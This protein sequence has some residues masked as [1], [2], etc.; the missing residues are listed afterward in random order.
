MPL[1]SVTLPAAGDAKPGGFVV[2]P[3]RLVL[4]GKEPAAVLTLQ[5]DSSQPARFELKMFAW[6]EGPHGEQNLTRTE[7]VLFFPTIFPLAAGE[8]RIVRLAYR[9]SIGPVEKTYRLIMSQ[10]PSV[11]K[12]E[13][14]PPG[15]RTLIRKRTLRCRCAGECSLF[16]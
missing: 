16:K 2:T 4:S 13:T 14:P 9:G 7:D 10:I 3:A 6:D 15:F 8:Q 5:N 11:E 12:E 1:L